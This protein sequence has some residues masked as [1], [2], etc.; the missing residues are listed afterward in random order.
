MRWYTEQGSRLEKF[1]AALNAVRLQ[2]DEFPLLVPLRW[3]V[4]DSSSPSRELVYY[5]LR[6]NARSQLTFVPTSSSLMPN[7][8]SESTR[9]TSVDEGLSGAVPRVYFMDSVRGVRL[10]QLEPSGSGAGGGS[11]SSSAHL[12][13]G[14]SPPERA[15]CI[16][17]VNEPPLHCVTP[18]ASE[19][20]EVVG[21]HLRRYNASRVAQ[22][23]ALKQL[24]ELKGTAYNSSEERHVKLLRRLWACGFGHD[25]PFQLQSERWVHLGFQSAD[26]AKD[27]R[28]MGVLGLANLVYFG[29]HY[30]DVF[31]RLVSAQRKRDYPLACAGINITSLLLELLN[32]KD[33]GE[34]ATVQG[35]APFDAEWGCD[36]FHFFCHMFY[37]DRAFEDMY[38]F[39]LR[40]L[41]RMYVSM[42]AD[43]ADFNTVL[44]ALKSRLVEALA[45]R[46]LSFREFKRLIAAGSV[47]S[48]S[49]SVTSNGITA[50]AS[51]TSSGDD[52]P[53]RSGDRGDASRRPMDHEQLASTIAEAM[54]Q[55]GSGLKGVLSKTLPGARQDGR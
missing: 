36:M 3:A 52:A 45:Q 46:P 34:P 53:R 19:V 43:Y 2:P 49:G 18:E 26:P 23:R 48:E 24:H 15:L 6:I 14:A 1:K 8:A 47:E 10:A 54:S 37:R 50:T 30:A 5:L 29:E 16:D 9:P 38:C 51:T 21:A 41:D 31:Q 33:E 17:L 25:Q 4:R 27:F 11:S 39:C 40:L 55:I 7:E 20:V 32:M 22:V 44:A 35:R 13:G 12:G 28:G 42:D